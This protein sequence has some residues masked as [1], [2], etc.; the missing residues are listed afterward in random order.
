MA[1]L[2]GSRDDSRDS[3]HGMAFGFWRDNLRVWEEIAHKRHSISLVINEEKDPSLAVTYRYLARAALELLSNT[4]KPANLTAVVRAGGY[5]GYGIVRL[6]SCSCNRDGRYPQP[7]AH[8]LSLRAF[9]T[10]CYPSAYIISLRGAKQLLSVMGGLTDELAMER[11]LADSVVNGYVR[12]YSLHAAESS[13]PR[14]SR[15]WDTPSDGAWGMLT[16]CPATSA[17]QIEK[18][19]TGWPGYIPS[20]N[21]VLGVGL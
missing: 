18:W 3:Q 20:L 15:R 16:F 1:R 7:G 21:E 10:Q 9:T 4:F 11:A 6:D 13:G 14:C 12:G 19:R 5:A 17:H 2:N 8:S